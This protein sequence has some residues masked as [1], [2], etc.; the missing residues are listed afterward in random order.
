M[1]EPKRAEWLSMLSDD[2]TEY[3]KKERLNNIGSHAGIKLHPE[4]L[5]SYRIYTTGKNGD[6]IFVGIAR[7]S[8]KYHKLVPDKVFLRL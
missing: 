3:D 2:E 8:D 4:Y 1:E 5:D 6:R 7:H